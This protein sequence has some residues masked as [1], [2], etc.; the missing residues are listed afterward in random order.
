MIDLHTHILPGVDD[1]SP[2]DYTSV[3]MAK[4]AADCGIKTIAA[5]PHVNQVGRF[6]NYDSP[7]LRERFSRLRELIKKEKIPV[8]IVEGMEIM[9]A[10]GIGRLIREKKVFGLNRGPYYLIEFPFEAESEWIEDRIEELLEIDAI[11]LIAHVERYHCVQKE[12]NLV[13][14]W[15][16]AGCRMQINKSSVFGR[17]GQ[18]SKKCAQILLSHDLVTCVASDAHSDEVRTTWMGDIQYHLVRNFSQHYMLHLLRSNP[19]RILKGSGIPPHGVPVRRSR[20]F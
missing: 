10:P 16:G 18:R 6:E 4:M 8:D 13:F 2:D 5:T 14:K 17:F 19:A 15:I 7:E 20:W 9:A 12:P 11:P 1:G 3:Q